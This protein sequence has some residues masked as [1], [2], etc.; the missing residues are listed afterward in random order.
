M[1]ATAPPHA[2][3]L[4]LLIKPYLRE[5]VAEV[6]AEELQVL[7]VHRTEVRAAALVQGL[8]GAGT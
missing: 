4:G 2:P 5:G 6:D 1:L 8:A 3:S 7:L